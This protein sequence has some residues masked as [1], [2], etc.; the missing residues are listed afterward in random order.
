MPRALPAL[1]I[2]RYPMPVR[3]RGPCLRV[4]DSSGSEIGAKSDLPNNR[5]FL[6][7]QS[8]NS[9]QTAGGGF[10]GAAPSDP[11][12]LRETGHTPGTEEI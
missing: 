3:A 11:P 12:D 4:R 8:R 1:P 5:T 7:H 9:A 10:C 2:D 6:R